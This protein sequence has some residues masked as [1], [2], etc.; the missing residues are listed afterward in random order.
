MPAARRAAARRLFPPLAQPDMLRATYRRDLLRYTR[1]ARSLLG[2]ELGPTLA[3]YGHFDAARMDT[4]RGEIR[5]AAE[6]AMARLEVEAPADYLAKLARKAA[7]ATDEHQR[8]QL[9]GAIRQ[10]LEISPKQ[11]FVREPDLGPAMASFINRNVSLIT[12]IPKRYFRKVEEIL[13]DA[14]EQGTRPETV[15]DLLEDRF[16][17]A[18][19]DAERIANDQIGKWNGQLNGLRQQALGVSSYIWRTMRDN[20]VRETHEDREGERFDWDDPPDEEEI[21]GHPGEPINCRCYAEPIL[22]DVALN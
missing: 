22:E 8:N 6:R 18:E 9:Y 19:S 15:A 7:R 20:R 14:M 17:V 13:G 2:H 10:H 16:G 4:T 5:K 12:T 1:R 21:D 11:L 3:A